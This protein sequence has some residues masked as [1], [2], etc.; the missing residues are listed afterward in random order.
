MERD[1]YGETLATV[2]VGAVTVGVAAMLLVDGVSLR[3]LMRVDA[4][5]LSEYVVALPRLHTVKSWL[6][7]LLANISGSIWEELVFRY[8]PYVQFKSQPW[9]LV[10]AIIFSSAI[11]GMQHISSG[12]RQVTYSCA[13]GCF[14][15]A[16]VWVTG[17]IW[18]SL[19]A[20]FVGNTFTL[21]IA[22]PLL[23]RKLRGYSAPF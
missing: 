14:F 19:A 21:A 1:A 15:S 2:G 9:L 3:Y 8:L 12:W 13:L 16:L 11:F 5:R 4:T 6:T 23:L 20:H 18:S 17:S 22:R 7:F 10:V